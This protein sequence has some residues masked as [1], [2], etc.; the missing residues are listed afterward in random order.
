MAGLS[1]STFI[2][3]PRASKP[4]QSMQVD[5][6]HRQQYVSTPELQAG[7]GRLQAERWLAR[8]QGARPDLKIL[9][10]T[11]LQAGLGTNRS[12]NWTLQVAGPAGPLAGFLGCSTP[13]SNG[14]AICSPLCSPLCYVQL[15]Q[16]ASSACV[17]FNPHAAWSVALSLQHT[18]GQRETARVA[19]GPVTGI[20]PTEASHRS[21]QACLSLIRRQ[22]SQK[23]QIQRPSGS[24]SF[25]HHFLKCQEGMLRIIELRQQLILQRRFFVPMFCLMARAE[26]PSRPLSTTAWNGISS[27]HH[28]FAKRRR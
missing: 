20:N 7:F 13:L 10:A 4:P 26:N 17:S 28:R 19:T 14:A 6:E 3:Q 5:C 22:A 18:T 12:H 11:A 2:M 25:S 27:K 1:V 23:S 24:R 9:V 21:N 15:Q 8:S 16:F